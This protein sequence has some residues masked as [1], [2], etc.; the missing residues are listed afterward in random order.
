MWR[1]SSRG[2]GIAAADRS[3]PVETAA[4]GADSSSRGE[5]IAAAEMSVPV[6]FKL[7]PSVVRSVP[8]A[9]VLRSADDI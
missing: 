5:G 7:R 2:R 9:I 6:E 1:H 4:A 3:V 8:R